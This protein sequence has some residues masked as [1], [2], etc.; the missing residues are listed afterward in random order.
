LDGAKL[1]SLNQV[2]EAGVAGLSSFLEAAS[3]D[4]TDTRESGEGEGTDGKSGSGVV[5][6]MTVHASK[7][8]EFGAVFL[9]GM[10]EGT[11]PH[12]RSLQSA[13]GLQVRHILGFSV[14][15]GIF[16]IGRGSSGQAYFRA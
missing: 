14:D 7:G 1:Q 12:A 15:F 16:A 8:L 6:V 10:E 3:L 13:E 5:S 4:A 9:V 11:F 2:T